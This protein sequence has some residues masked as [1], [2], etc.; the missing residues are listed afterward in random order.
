MA[1]IAVV[2]VAGDAFQQVDVMK[3]THE[4]KSIQISI[5]PIEDDDDIRTGHS[6]DSVYVGRSRQ[7]TEERIMQLQQDISVLKVDLERCIHEAVAGS[8]T[9]SSAEK[10]KK[11]QGKTN[12]AYKAW[13]ARELV[14]SDLLVGLDCL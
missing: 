11:L 8:Q 10:K 6:T 12:A 2:N 7:N 9:S 14:L 4:S 5:A 13:A 3:S 1:T